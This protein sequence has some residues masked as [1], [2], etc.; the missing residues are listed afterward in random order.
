MLGLVVGLLDAACG[1]GDVPLDQ[2]ERWKCRINI[3]SKSAR[4]C[5]ACNSDADC[6]GFLTPYTFCAKGRSADKT[7]FGGCIA[8]VNTGG[9]NAGDCDLQMRDITP[10]QV[11]GQTFNADTCVPKGTAAADADSC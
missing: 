8:P 10:Q 5:K 4:T 2:Q 3:I 1:S 7:V 6:E 9:V 11:G